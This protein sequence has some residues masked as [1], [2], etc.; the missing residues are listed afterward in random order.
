MACIF[1]YRLQFT[2]SHIGPLQVYSSFLDVSNDFAAASSLS[3]STLTNSSLSLSLS[4]DS[5]I[6][7]TTSSGVGSFTCSFGSFSTSCVVTGAGDSCTISIFL[8]FFS[9][10]F[11]SLGTVTCSTPSDSLALILFVS[12][13]LLILNILLIFD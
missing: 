10:F 13:L 8:L 7:I 11:S 9:S 2:E 12:A 1:P 3:S 6:V 4:T 5:D